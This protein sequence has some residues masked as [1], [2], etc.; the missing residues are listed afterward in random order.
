MPS[1]KPR[2]RR[3]PKAVPTKFVKLRGKVFNAERGWRAKVD[4]RRRVLEALG[5][6]QTRVFD[7]YA[8]PGLMYR[9][10]WAQAARYVGCDET[11]FKDDRCCFVADNRRVLRCIDLQ[12]FTCFD[13]DAFGSPWEQVLI[14]AAR[15]H[16]AA[17]E[18]LGLILTEGSSIYTRQ[19]GLPHA[20]REAAGLTR[21]ADKGTGRVHD[22]MISRALY[23]TVR[24]MGGKV[25]REWWANGASAAKMRYIGVV[26][27]G[28]PHESASL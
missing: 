13:F 2:H 18:R 22:E 7:A 27:E 5:P 1:R 14:L 21:A 25:V 12:A 9:E 4:V 24:R 19:S 15:R 6:A 10:V 11:W 17:G 28:V 8:G 16:L 26:V 23:R 20:F 3:Q